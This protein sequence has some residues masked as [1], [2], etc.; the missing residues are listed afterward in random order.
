MKKVKVSG[1]MYDLFFQLA[2]RLCNIEYRFLVYEAFRKFLSLGIY[3]KVCH[4][5]I[6]R[7]ISKEKF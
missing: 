3:S 5:F 1:L 2:D 7:K 6:Y 4:A